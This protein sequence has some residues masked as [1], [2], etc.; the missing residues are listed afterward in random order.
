MKK[1]REGIWCF[2]SLICHS[3]WPGLSDEGGRDRFV[4]RACV[5]L[6]N[7]IVEDECDSYELVFDYDVVEESS[8]PSTVSQERHLCYEM[9]FQRTV[10]M[11]SW[12]AYLIKTRMT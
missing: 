8:P 10:V 3:A 6:H 12:E 4:M 1:C 5:I 7:M 2:T 11:Y 9:Y